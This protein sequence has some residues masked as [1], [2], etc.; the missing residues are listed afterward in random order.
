EG[1]EGLGVEPQPREDLRAINPIRAWTQL[2][3]M[4]GAA[5]EPVDAIRLQ[6]DD[7]VL[8]NSRALV[9]GL[10]LGQIVDAAG[11]GDLDDQLGPTG[12]VAVRVFTAPA[13]AFG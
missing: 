6:R 2:P 12:V 7:Q 11:T 3:E 13:A 9:V 10:L 5:N 4:A 1:E 8:L